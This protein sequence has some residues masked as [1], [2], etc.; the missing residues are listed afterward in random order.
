MFKVI[1]FTLILFSTL[2]SSEIILTSGSKS[3]TYI[4][5]AQDIAEKVVNNSNLGFKIK[6]LESNGSKENLKRLALNK[7]QLAIVQHDVIQI[8]KDILDSPEPR[9]PKERELYKKYQELDKN[10]RILIPLYIEQ[11]HIIVRKNDPNIRNFQNLKDKKLS[12]GAIGSGTSMT[13][14]LIYKKIFGKT[15]KKSQIDR[16]SLEDALRK[17]KENKVDAV[18]SVGGYP[19]SPLTKSGDF[20]LISLSLKKYKSLEENYYDT[21]IPASTY[22][23]QEDEIKTVGIYS[24]LICNKKNFISAQEIKKFGK[25]F[26]QKLGILKEHGKAKNKWKDVNKSILPALPSSK[27]WEY[28]KEFKEGWEEDYYKN[29]IPLPDKTKDKKGRVRE[30]GFM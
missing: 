16:S 19:I 15:P 11:L 20:R 28:C 29:I 21:T 9:N 4:K 2:F 5:I 18:F 6:V 23:W 26:N 14:I 8:L 13:S 25:I 10:I 3:G 1:F 17:L 12:I 22:P 27:K 7:A 30:D 24:F